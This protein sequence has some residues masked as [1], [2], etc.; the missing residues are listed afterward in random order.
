MKAQQ[1]QEEFAVRYYRWAQAD[2]Q[3]EAMESFGLLRGVRSS[4]AFSALRFI[5]ELQPEEQP[6]YF[7]VFT[8][9]GH[10]L[11]ARITGQMLS[12]GEEELFQRFRTARLVPLPIETEIALKP[13]MKVSHFAAEAKARLRRIFGEPES[14]PEGGSERFVTSVGAWRLITLVNYGHYPYSFQSIETERGDRLQEHISLLA[15]LGL[16]GQTVWD[17]AREGDELDS[18]LALTACCEHFLK[19]APGL[20]A[21]LSDNPDAESGSGWDWLKKLEAS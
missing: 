14:R 19:A 1:A 8:K 16:G 21:G 18:A 13:R 10:P 15:W 17:L 9:K 4:L 3:R 20:L 5:D 2:W 12:A 11:A 7:T 6:Q